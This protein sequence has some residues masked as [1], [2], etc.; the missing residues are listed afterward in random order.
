MGS[1]DFEILDVLQEKIFTALELGARH[2]CYLYCA[3][4]IVHAKQLRDNDGLPQSEYRTV[5]DT[6]SDVY[7][8]LFSNPVS[9]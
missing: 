6:C 3:Q 1:E 4:F 5:L 8:A 9:K 2:D 7:A